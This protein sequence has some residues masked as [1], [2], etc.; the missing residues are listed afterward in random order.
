MRS[1]LINKIKY[2]A[3]MIAAILV[4][5]CG[6]DLAGTGAPSTMISVENI[7]ATPVYVL[8]NASVGEPSADDMSHPATSAAF[9]PRKVYENL[10]GGT[11]MAAGARPAVVTVFTP[12]Q[13]RAAYGLAPL[14]STGTV[15]S[16]SAAALQGAGQTIY[17]IDAYHDPNVS[18]ELAAF[19]TK[20]GLPGCTQKS[21]PTSATLPLQPAAVADGCTLSVVYSTAT[22][23]MTT[24]APIY[25][26]GWATEIALDVQ[27]AHATAPR[28]RIILIEAA[29]ASIASLTAAVKLA[30]SMGPGVVS[31]SFGAKEGTWSAQYNSIFSAPGMN[32]FAATGDWGTGVYWP[33]SAPNVLAVGGTTLSV[34]A[35]GARSETVWSGTGGGMSNFTNTPAYQFNTVPGI[36]TPAQKLVADVAFNADPYSGQYTAVQPN[37]SGIVSWVGAG[38]TSLSTPQ[39]AALVAIANAQRAL[40]SVPRISSTHAL[41]Y[42]KIAADPTKYAAGF[43]D[44]KSGANGTG[45]L[46]TARVGYDTPTGLGTPNISALLGLLQTLPNPVPPT[47]SSAAIKGTGFVPLTFAV[48]SNAVRPVYVLDGAPGGMVISTTGVVSWPSPVAG[49]WTVGITANDTASG[50]STRGV[51]TLSIA[52]GS[53]PVISAPSFTGVTTRAFTGQISFADPN[54]LQF[55]FNIGKVPTGMTYARSGNSYVLSWTRPVAGKYTI[56]VSAT[57]SAGLS[58]TVNVPLTIS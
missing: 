33:S 43:Y 11:V 46:C 17:I 32:Y 26:S 8:A 35:S 41:L 22:A 42:N 24:T 20:F 30:N 18:A 56:T 39:W 36:G 40:V 7:E 27:W 45:A 49:N 55:T 2:I 4:I 37:G 6:G 3:P 13:I 28:A 48:T 38:G 31:M 44:V 14:P 25:N 52:P 50:L 16:S 1:N 57:N 47:M 9:T 12:A 34:A 58:T 53:A 5:G 54:N 23:Q 51:Y 21:I 29:D 19:N 10:R 15:L